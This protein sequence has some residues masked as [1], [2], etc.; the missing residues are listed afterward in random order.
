MTRPRPTPFSRLLRSAFSAAGAVALVTA[1]LA[2][3]A[4]AQN[5]GAPYAGIVTVEVFANSAMVITPTQSDRYKLVVYRMDSME[6]L[7]QQINQKIPRGGAGP[8]RAWLIANADRIKREFRPVAAQSANAMNLSH[9]Y[10]LDRLPA[11]V[12][13]RKS[14]VYGVTDVE[15]AVQRYQ[16]SRRSK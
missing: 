3:T 11:I 13:N 6:I 7:R 15:T 1:T 14:V 2:S 12:I 16:A 9:Y 4:V 8:A 10:H 5:S